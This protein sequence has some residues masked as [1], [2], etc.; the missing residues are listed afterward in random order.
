ME[1]WLQIWQWLLAN[2]RWL[3]VLAGTILGLFYLIFGF[4]KTLVF[5]LFVFLGFYI[6]KMADDREDWRDVIDRI[7]PQQFRE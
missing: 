1:K 3:G 4:L 7:V 6:G 5:A 2:K